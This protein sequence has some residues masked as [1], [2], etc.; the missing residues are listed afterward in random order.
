MIVGIYSITSPSGKVYVGKSTNI[1]N[2]WKS[3]QSLTCSS[4]I[5]I[6]NSLCRYEPERHVFR[7]LEE[8]PKDVKGD[9]LGIAEQKWYDT[10]VSEIGEDNMLNCH[11][12]ILSGNYIPERVVKRF[13]K[14]P[15]KRAS[16]ISKTERKSYI[17]KEADCNLLLTISIL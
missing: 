1:K 13:Y 4:Q 16:R 12:P 3:Y 8:F 9:I 14:K 15:V 11:R 7:I 6:Y 2:R 10:V 5:K 17:E